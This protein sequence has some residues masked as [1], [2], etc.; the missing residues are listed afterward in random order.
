MAESS[1]I[2]YGDPDDY[3]ARFGDIHVNLT[4]TGAGEFKARLTRLKL[5]HLEICGLRESLPRIAYISLPPEQI[6]LSFPA[7]KVSPIVDGV[8]IRNGD[9]VLAGR[10]ACM[11]Q[12]SSGECQ[13][14]LISLSPERFASCGKALTGRQVHIPQASRILRPART[15]MSRFQ[16]LFKQVCRLAEARQKLIEH[17][18]VARALEEELFHAIIDCLTANETDDNPKT[19][20]R[21]SRG[22][23]S[24]RRDAKQAH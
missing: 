13:W 19:R 17:H 6:Y 18:E 7:G 9:I 14:G 2:V 23:G 15:E 24:F 20:R 10:G 8:A 12:R 22:H 4:I 3:A 16:R 1:T 5:E 21:H 11:H